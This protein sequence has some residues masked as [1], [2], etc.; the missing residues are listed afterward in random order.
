ST[1]FRS[2]GLRARLARLTPDDGAV[3]PVIAHLTSSVVQRPD[4]VPRTASGSH[5]WLIGAIS[6]RWPSRPAL[7]NPSE[8]TRS[9]A[10]VEPGSSTASRVAEQAKPRLLHVSNGRRVGS[11]R[12]YAQQ[13]P[14]SGAASPDLASTPSNH[15]RQ[16]GGSVAM[17]RA[18]RTP[19]RLPS[20]K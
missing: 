1:R 9:P 7:W 12:S 18:L 2:S 8:A 10:E 20:S 16:S 15:S 14:F 13:V 5:V 19:C 3:I 4:R 11:V 17:R 6:A